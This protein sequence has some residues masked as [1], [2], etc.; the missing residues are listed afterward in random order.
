MGRL[1]L[2]IDEPAALYRCQQHRRGI[3][4]ACAIDEPAEVRGERH[5]RIGVSF[6]VL[7]VVVAEA[8]QQEI[9]GAEI[10]DRPVEQPCLDEAARRR[11]RESVVHDLEPVLRGECLSPARARRLVR[12]VVAG[13]RV[14]RDDDAHRIS[15]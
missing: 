8:H 3:A 15:P 5:L 6:V 12:G 10:L 9:A 1:E 13:G 2:P 4:V 7:A 11:S 14:A